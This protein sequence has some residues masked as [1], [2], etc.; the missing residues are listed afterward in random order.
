[1]SL[2]LVGHPI[3]GNFTCLCESGFEGELCTKDVDECSTNRTDCNKYATCSNTHGSYVCNCAR[4]YYGTGFSC[5]PGNCPDENCPENQQCISETTT[6][7][8]C[9]DG[10]LLDS[11]YCV[12][13]DECQETR[14]DENSDC[15]NT[16]GS[17]TCRSIDTGLNTI[18]V[19]GSETDITNGREP[20]WKLP[21]LINA[22]GTN[23]TL[24]CLDFNFPD[25][26][27]DVEAKWACSVIWQDQFYLFGGFQQAGQISRLNGHNLQR[28]GDLAFW[29]FGPACS[30]LGEEIFLCF[31]VALN[32]ANMEE[33]K[34]CRKAAG[35]LQFSDESKFEVIST[36][37]PHCFS[38][39]PVSESKYASTKPDTPHRPIMFS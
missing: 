15:L 14:C 5:F 28:I 35:P 31:G 24:D 7:C 16:I 3:A 37:E 12:D 26:K 9:K 32:F 39:T 33:N 30:T 1:M 19:L 4:G 20:I 34:R 10:F 2:F 25:E 23:E 13:Y 18:L 38:S 29:H 27:E 17:Y 8:E 22:D 11:T 36:N 6:G 21:L